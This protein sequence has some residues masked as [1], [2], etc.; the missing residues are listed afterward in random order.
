M[1]KYC[2]MA[3]SNFVDELLSEL[4][5]RDWSVNQLAKRSHISP[6]YIGRVIRGERT[7][8]TDACRAIARAF[9]KNENEYLALAGLAAPGPVPSDVRDRVRQQLDQ[10]SE[11]QLKVV[12]RTARALLAEQLLESL[13]AEP[14]KPQ[15]NPNR[16]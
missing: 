9:G 8:G 4:K 6:G 5:I 3:T 10:M 13:R 1:L 12:E 11:E 2:L 7:I 16:P 15:T 14:Q